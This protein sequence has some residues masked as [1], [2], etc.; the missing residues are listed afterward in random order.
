MPCVSYKRLEEWRKKESLEKELEIYKKL[1]N[2]L[3]N[4]YKENKN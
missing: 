2:T 3:V 4:T 1:V